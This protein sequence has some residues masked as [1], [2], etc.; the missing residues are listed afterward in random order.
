MNFEAATTISK[1]S[2]AS[3]E[4]KSKLEINTCSS[5]VRKEICLKQLNTS[6][7]QNKGCFK[8]IHLKPLGLGIGKIPLQPSGNHILKTMSPTLYSIV[9]TFRSQ[10]SRRSKIG[11][12]KKNFI[13]HTSITP[14]FLFMNYYKA[15]SQLHVQQFP[16]I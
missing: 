14:S 4:L 9:S 15:F 13:P 2:N 3:Y 8:Q 10:M 16:L 6:Q 1:N 11:L 7:L 5:F 12:Q